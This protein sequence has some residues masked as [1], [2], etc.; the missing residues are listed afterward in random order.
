MRGLFAAL[1]D[2]RLLVPVR[3]KTREGVELAVVES[4]QGTTFHG[5]TDEQALLAAHPAG[6]PYITMSMPTLA[7]VVLEDSTATLVVD[8]GS[9]DAGRLSRADLELLRDR[10]I[11][12]PGGSATAAPGE[13]LRVFAWNEP[14]SSVVRAVRAT[15][16]AQ[17]GLQALLLFKGAFA[18]GEPHAM[19][20]ARFANDI[21]DSERRRALAA[22][23]ASARPYL[24]TGE[25]FD[26]VDLSDQLGE[27]VTSV[28]QL[29]WSRS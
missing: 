1:R 5:F 26:V 22:L 17:R 7:G 23:S 18:G 13:S 14:P 19:L 12:G 3:G 10:L 29:V 20:A 25:T 8:P 11:P 28:A 21:G 6:A 24:E 9:A 15:A 4:P 27:A 16:P 2:S